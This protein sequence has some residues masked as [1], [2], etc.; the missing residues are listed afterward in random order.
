MM[1]PGFNDFLIY[2][3]MKEEGRP[4]SHILGSAASNPD[5]KP[6]LFYE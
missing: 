2:G 1:S 3:F 5:D 6:P 4:S